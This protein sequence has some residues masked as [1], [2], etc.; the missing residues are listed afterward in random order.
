[1][2]TWKKTG[3]NSFQKPS[4]LIIECKIRNSP[5]HKIVLPWLHL[6]VCTHMQT[7]IHAYTH[8]HLKWPFTCYPP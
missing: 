8:I 3:L 4:P 1:M 7:H 2:M 6:Y 5:A